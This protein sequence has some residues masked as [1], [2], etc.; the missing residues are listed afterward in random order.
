M[1]YLILH[2]LLQRNQIQTTISFNFIKNLTCPSLLY[3]TF[4]F[5]FQ[6]LQMCCV[7]RKG[8]GVLHINQ[9]KIPMYSTYQTDILKLILHND[10]HHHKSSFTKPLDVIH[11][12]T[13]KSTLPFHPFYFECSSQAVSRHIRTFFLAALGCQFGI[14]LKL[15]TVSCGED[16]VHLLSIL[17][18]IF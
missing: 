12:C 3:C 8:T 10:F 1:F 15:C 7:A 2:P 18:A 6:L 4:L 9:T 11:A 5:S 14:T 13:G 17:E 16:E